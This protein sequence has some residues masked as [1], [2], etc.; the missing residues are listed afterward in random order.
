MAKIRLA[1]PHEEFPVTQ[2]GFAR[3]FGFTT[4]AVRDWEQKRFKP[5]GVARVLLTL[6][7]HDPVATEA[8]I[9]AALAPHAE[10]PRS[11]E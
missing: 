9:H 4:A 1:V 11:V 6:I 10:D 7:A 3:R 8:L 2:E 5:E